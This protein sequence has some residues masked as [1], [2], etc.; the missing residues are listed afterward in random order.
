[1]IIKSIRQ[2]TRFA[3]LTGALMLSAC[4]ATFQNHGYVPE[5][6]ALD[7]LVVG[8]DTRGSLED[9]V[10]PPSSTGVMDDEG[11]FYISSKIRHYAYLRPQVVER[12]MVAVTF[13]DDETITNIQRFG[14]QDGNVI[15]LNRRVTELPVKGP[16]ILGQ[17]LG[18]FGNIN[19]ADAIGGGG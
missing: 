14:L 3:V 19:V 12:E 10:G 18:T 2:G 16:S 5:Q 8:V 1:M 13:G 9:I 7:E 6:D 4:S 17:I 15:T 11:W